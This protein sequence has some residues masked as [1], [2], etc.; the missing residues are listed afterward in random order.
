VNQYDGRSSNNVGDAGPNQSSPS[1]TVVSAIISLLRCFWKKRREQVHYGFHQWS[2]PATTK[3]ACPLPPKKLGIQPDLID[4]LLACYPTSQSGMQER[5]EGTAIT[6][7]SFPP[8]SWLHAR[9]I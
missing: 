7:P 2:L 9:I 6:C 4:C 3:S 8:I 1:E 5:T